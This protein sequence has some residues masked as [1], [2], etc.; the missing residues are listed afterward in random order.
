MTEYFLAPAAAILL[1]GGFGTLCVGLIHRF[2]YGILIFGPITAG[3]LLILF[4]VSLVG[5]FSAVWQENR[6]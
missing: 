4:F 3:A 5:V 6:S 1:L 2:F